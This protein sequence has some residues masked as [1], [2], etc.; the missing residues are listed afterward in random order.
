VDDHPLDD[1]PATAEDAQP[2]AS[3]ATPRPAVMAAAHLT[4][5]APRTAV[6]VDTAAVVT[7]DMGGKTALGPL[8]A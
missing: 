6:A 8:P 2:Q 7:V 3:V 5:A 4:E 1:H